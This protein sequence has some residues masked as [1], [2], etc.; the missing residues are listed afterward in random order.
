MLDL[1]HRLSAFPGTSALVRSIVNEVLELAALRRLP[2]TF[3]GELPDDLQPR[4]AR[5]PRRW[6]EAT[7]GPPARSTWPRTARDYADGYRRRAADPVEVVERALASLAELARRT[8]SMNVLASWDPEGARAAARVARERIAHG[9]ARPLEGVPFLAKDQHDVAGLPTRFG[10]R[11]DA[12]AAGDDATIIAR[13]RGAGAIVLG[14]SVMT[15]WGISPLGNNVHVEMPRNPHVPSRAAG[16]SSTGSA[17]A[18][19]FGIGPFATA[20]DAGGSARIPAAWSGV[21]GLKPTYGRISRAGEA[22]SGT[23]N[24]VGAVAVSS[25][26][27]ALFLDA[28]STMSDPDDASTEWAPAPDPAG[29]GARMGDGAR[30]LRIGI[31]EHEWRDAPTD[32]AHACREAL[33]ALERDGAALVPV[34]MPLA[35]HAPALGIATIGCEGVALANTVEPGLRAALAVDARLAMNVAA[36]VSAGD[37]LDVQRLRRGLRD[38]LAA[39]LRAADIIASPTLAST[40]PRLTNREMSGSFSDARLVVDAC[41]FTFLANLT[42]TPA[43]TAPVGV[44]HDGVPIGLQL[45]GDAWDEAGLLSVLAH[46]ERIGAAR[47]IQPPGA[48]DL[49]GDS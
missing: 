15:E 33:R 12:L 26:D 13:L 35:R 3:R 46:L 11:V 2:D 34:R 22:F 43:V 48:I 40:S 10:T 4:R 30:G 18:V 39:A 42:G 24:H 16:G 8:P 9:V 36:G 1:V 44:D 31:D 5:A 27:L 6:N 37:Y 32:I 20:G 38:Q 41:R 21:L 19:A 28:V 7:F 45:L 23:L 49:L 14:K 17:V 29:F 25:A 47:V